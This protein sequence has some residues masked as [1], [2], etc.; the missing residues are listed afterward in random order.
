M[1]N[2]IFTKTISLE[3]FM[4]DPSHNNNGHII[5]EE[6][7][8]LHNQQQW[9]PYGWRIYEIMQGFRVFGSASPE[10]SLRRL[11][12]RLQVCHPYLHASYR[13]SQTGD[14]LMVG[15]TEWPPT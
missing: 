15:A 8:G 7:H 1:R 13:K 11:S 2:L 4:E 10:R 14:D 5:D 3:G 9:V 6:V 12:S